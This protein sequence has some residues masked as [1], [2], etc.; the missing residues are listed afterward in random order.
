[1]DI[2]LL[3]LLLAPLLVVTSTL[4]GRRWGPA[5]TGM[6]IALPI[7]A[8]PILYIVYEEHGSEF[9]GEAA[10][11]AL[12]GLVSLAVFAVVFTRVAR[13]FGGLATLAAS[14]AAVLAVDVALSFY[15]VPDPVALATTLAATAVATLFMPRTDRDR[16][17]EPP[18]PPIW[19]LP[20]RAVATVILV[21][22]IT[23]AS[24]LLGP[25]WTGI[26]APFPI[27]TSVV[28]A[29]V[30]AQ[31]GA[32]AAARLLS[33]V[34]IGLFGFATFCFSVAVLVRPFGAIA[35]ILG[36]AT[37]VATQIVV[38]RLRRRRRPAPRDTA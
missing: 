2:L 33:G 19:D 10:G 11:A 22:S 28:A 32:A 15:R 31:D 12:L 35:F 36:S 30:L 29:F 8:G 5:A 17:V 25:Q 18:P 26:L 34:L 1:M 23:T 38:V 24:G 13:R 4:A 6:L 27:A 3:K 14:W 20:G 37:A 7:V 16:D 9:A 21:V